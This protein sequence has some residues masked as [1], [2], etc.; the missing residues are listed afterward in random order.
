MRLWPPTFDAALLPLARLAPHTV[1]RTVA[2]AAASKDPQTIG[3]CGVGLLEQVALRSFG[4]RGSDLCVVFGRQRKPR[5]R[6]LGLSN[7]TIEGPCLVRRGR[8]RRSTH[9]TSFANRGQRFRLRTS[10]IEFLSRRCE[11]GL[12]HARNEAR[13]MEIAL[14]FGERGKRIRY[15]ASLADVRGRH[16]P[17]LRALC[18]DLVEPRC[19]RSLFC[20]KHAALLKRRRSSLQFLRR[21]VGEKFI[22]PGRERFAIGR[23]C[24]SRHLAVDFLKARQFRAAAGSP[25]ARLP[26]FCSISALRARK[27]ASSA[28]SRNACSSMVGSVNG[29][30]ACM[31]STSDRADAKIGPTSTSRP[32]RTCATAAL[33]ASR[34][35]AASALMMGAACAIN[36][37]G[38]RYPASRAA[39]MPDKSARRLPHRRRDR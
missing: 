7:L 11:L 28:V 2:A 30:T 35:V 27:P 33:V 17:Q 23:R 19:D 4:T 29:V 22:T 3:R 20:R 15:D 13:L 16:C 14:L 8:L 32:S 36:A 24:C 1:N 12:R 26:R 5:R 34:W 6:L 31:P 9:R 38:L 25:G 10:T 21:R 18:G 37:S 39:P